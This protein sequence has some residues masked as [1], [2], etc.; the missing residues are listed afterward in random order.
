MEFIIYLIIFVFGTVIGSFYNVLGY[1]LPK[2]ESIVF[3]SSHCPNCNHQLNFFD[4]FPIFSYIFLKGKCRYCKQKIS[5]IYPLIELLT[6]ILFVIS[7]HIFGFSIEF[8]IALIFSSVAVI[9]I[10][11]DTRYMIINDEILIIGSI[12]ILIL[13]FI[14]K[15]LNVTLDK[16][17]QGLISF[18]L[19]FI[20]KLAADYSFKKEAMGGGDVKLMF[21]IGIVTSAPMSFITLCFS[22]FVAFP[23]AIYIYFSKKENILPL[24]PFLC[25]AALLIYFSGITFTDLMNL[26]AN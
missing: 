15:G 10:V 11:S 17:F 20:I 25:I 2:K 18:G 7:Y 9:T 8:A 12:A 4:L 19:F 24:G 21:V 6:G 3:P 22:S 16:F 13:T 1:R 14:D 5:I 23:Y 26:M